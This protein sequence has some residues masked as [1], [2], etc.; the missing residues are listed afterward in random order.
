[1]TEV[2]SWFLGPK[3]ENADYVKDLI[4]EIFVDYIHWRKNFHPEDEFFVT[5]EERIKGDFQKRISILK[6]ELWKI[7]AELKKDVPFFSPRYIAHMQNECCIPGIIGYIAAMLYNPNNVT[8]ESSPRTT[9]YEVELAKEFAKMIG[10]KDYQ[11]SWGHITSGGTIA[12]LEALWVARNLKYYPLAIKLALQHGGFKKY[13]G[14]PFKDRRFVEWSPSE[15]LCLPTDEVLE[16]ESILFAYKLRED[17][18]QDL[19]SKKKERALFDLRKCINKYTIKELGFWEFKKRVSREFGEEFADQL[20]GVVL[21]P[22]AKHYSWEKIIDIVGIGETALKLVPID[23]NFR[24][25]S[26]ELADKINSGTKGEQIIMVVAVPGTTEEGALDPV[27]EI[28]KLKKQHKF[29]LHLDAA[30][31]GYF[32]SLIWKK[33]DIPIRTLDEFK[34]QFSAILS[35]E[36]LDHLYRTLIAFREA[37]SIT[38]DPHK[39]GYIPYPAG[40]IVFKDK[41]VRNFLSHDAPYIFQEEERERIF[42]GKYIL[43]GSKPGAA[44]AACYL[45]S[46]VIP[47]SMEGYGAILRETLEGAKRL[48]NVLID[49]YIPGIRIVTLSEPDTNIVTFV[50][51]IEENND[52]ARMNEL[53]KGVYKYFSPYGGE[54]KP[55]QDYD[56]IISKTSFQWS[57]YN[58]PATDRLLEKAGVDLEKYQERPDEEKGESNKIEVLC[59]TVMNPWTREDYYIKKFKEALSRVIRSFSLDTIIVEDN[60]DDVDGIK[61]N[62][63]EL[64]PIT[65]FSPRVAN[66]FEDGKRELST[67]PDLLILDLNL[68]PKNGEPEEAFMGA[69]LIP[70]LR[71][72]DEGKKVPIVVYTINPPDKILRSQLEKRGFNPDID[73]VV[74]KKDPKNEVKLIREILDVRRKKLL[75]S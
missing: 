32:S 34:S 29:Y 48:Y 62:L 24:M 20:N 36:R 8:S 30:Y 71:E 57:A 39:L 73:R 60:P 75:E 53:V 37:D 4:Q 63:N 1:M 3:G 28:T 11:N 9:E 45:A 16:L 67:I 23:E 68:P 6:Q 26:K 7:L 66:N 5:E 15:L 35:E 44:A 27:Y 51:N 56:F 2:R 61:E 17:G 49:I 70:R 19:D 13:Q 43:E 42:I 58:G 22:K 40:S 74:Y 55:I 46:K 25:N 47:L 59:L 14:V 69:E 65:Y 12:N 10:F 52:L 33:S 64:S 31:G 18:I 38:I 41:R 72:K 21:V 50:I 54:K